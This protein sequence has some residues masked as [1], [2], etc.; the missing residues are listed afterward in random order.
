MLAFADFDKPFLLETDA[1]KLGLR[2]VL[3][4]KQ[5]DSQY[6]PVAYASQSLTT[7]KCNCH[8]T[9]QEFLLLK[10]A[11]EEQF[12]EYLLWKPFIVKTD[13]NPLTYIM[14]TPNLDA[15]WNQWI[16]SL[17]WFIFSIKYQKGHDNVAT[18]ALSHVTSKLNTDTIKSI[19]DGVAMGITKRAHAHDPT[20]AQADEEIHKPFQE[21]MILAQAT[22]VD[23]HVTGSITQGSNLVDLWPKSVGSQTPAGRWCN[24]WRG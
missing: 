1:S 12:Q 24:Y 9:K 17:A 5:A 13:N 14:T 2:A 16:E 23:L 8:S 21:T 10:W 11:I 6:H 7:H 15:T 3:S 19:L 4:Q 22:Q 20:V 18:D